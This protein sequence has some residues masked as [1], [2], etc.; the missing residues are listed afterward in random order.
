MRDSMRSGPRGGLPPLALSL[1]LA[2][3][4]LSPAVQAQSGAAAVVQ[5]YDIPPGALGPALNR[6]AQEAGVSLAVDASRVAGATTAG[7]QGRYG[8][9]EGFAQLLKGSGHT[10]RKTGAGYG[11]AP[12]LPASVPAAPA[13]GEQ[14]RTGTRPAPA[15]AAAADAAAPTGDAAQDAPAAR[16]TAGRGTLE[17]VT[18]SASRSN[19]EAEKAPQTV[20]IIQRAQIEQQL[21]LSTNSSDV[22]SNLIPSYTPSRGK[23]NGS[24]ETLR[25][26]TPLILVDGVPQSNPIRPTGREAHTIDFAMIDRVEVVQGANAINGLGATGGTINLITKRPENGALN[27]HVDVQATAPAGHGGS[28]SL[29]TKMAYSANGRQDRLDYLFSIAVEDQGLWRDARGRGIGADNTQGDLMDARSHDVLGKLGYWLD[30]DQRLQLSVNRYRIKSQSHYIGVAGDRARG[31]PTTSIEGTPAGAPPF[32]E[33]QTSAITY[34]HYN[35]AGMELSALAFSQEF[36]ALFGGDR[37]ATFQDPLIAPRGTLVDQSRAKSSKLGTKVTLTKADLLNSRLKLTGGFDTLVD[38][39]KQDLFGTGRTYVP[40][41][42]YRNLALFLQGE[43]R[44]LDKVTLHGGVRREYADLKV[45]SY[46]TLAAYNRVAV[47]GGTLDFDET[48]YNAGIVYEPARDWNVYASYS[49]GFGMPDVGRVLRSINTPGQNVDDMKSLSPIVTQS[50]ELGTRVK[51]GDWDAEASWFRSSSDYGTRVLRVNEAFMLAREKNR[52]DG[53]EASLGWQVHRAHKARL[54][55][56]RTRGRYDSNND[57]RLDA[58]LDGLNIAPD[59]L[60]ASWTAQW[61]E[62]LSSFVQVQRAFSRTFDNPAMN[63]SGYT[64]VDAS[65]QYRLPKGRV[66]LAVANL[67]NRDYITYYSQSALVEP[68]RYFAGRGRTLTLGYSVDF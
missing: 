20:Q 42:E 25:G 22:L 21:A 29:S 17:T 60:V 63:F 1:S 67:F 6:F 35:L 43:Y 14:D 12:A 44:L 68:L 30:D 64:L 27:Q 37:S 48:L 24:G 15:Q 2:M 40:E 46:R 45:D 8:V 62:Q 32:N 28:D 18:V 61:N 56:S 3:A 55:Y 38:K 49:E 31:I 66:R 5:A 65:L 57:G 7:L 53:L 26:R 34:D 54:A 10:I 9:E 50:V 39:G 47:Q 16:A 13:A 19:M 41:S 11:L 23:M 33:V 51:R 4:A 59:R 36:E 58:R 52:I